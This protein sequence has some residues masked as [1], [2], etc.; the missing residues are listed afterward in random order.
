MSHPCSQFDS[1]KQV[2]FDAVNTNLWNRS[3]KKRG[4]Y[5][6]SYMRGAEST[7]PKIWPKDKT[8]ILWVG[9]ELFSIISY[10][11]FDHRQ[12]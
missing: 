9:Q 4:G 10:N 11:K 12:G 1:S 6:V 5:M 2:S 8:E 7:L 3:K